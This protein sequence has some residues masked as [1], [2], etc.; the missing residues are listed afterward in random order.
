M[1]KLLFRKK[2][3]IRV[4]ALQSFSGGGGQGAAHHPKGTFQKSQSPKT[5][6]AAN[7]LQL[8]PGF[9]GYAK[10]DQPGL[11]AGKPK[12]QKIPQT[13]QTEGGKCT[14]YNIKN[15]PIHLTTSLWAVWRW[16]LSLSYYI[17]RN[18]K[19]TISGTS[20][21]VCFFAPNVV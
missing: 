15:H 16:V 5:L 1:R 3:Y 21:F 8:L 18:L 12:D 10:K 9:W 7:G 13:E 19:S 14:Y 6:I 4:L 11:F 20:S 2:S 17:L